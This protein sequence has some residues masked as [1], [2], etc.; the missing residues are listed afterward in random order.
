LPAEY[1]VGIVGKA[2]QRFE[3]GIGILDLVQVRRRIVTRA[4]VLVI[5]AAALPRGADAEGAGFGAATPV[6][7]SA[8]MGVPPQPPTISA[9]ARTEAQLTAEGAQRSA[10]RF[11]CVRCGESVFP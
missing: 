10:S 5:A 11:L 7:R 6:S 2:M 8:R 3:P 9:T 1:G 4:I